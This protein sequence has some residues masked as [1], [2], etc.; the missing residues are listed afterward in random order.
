MKRSFLRSLFVRVGNWFGL[1]PEVGDLISAG[2]RLTNPGQADV[3]SE[4]LNFAS[5]LIASGIW[6]YCFFQFYRNFVGPYWVERQY[7]P[8][9]VSF[10]PRAVSPLSINVTHRT[11]MGFRGPNSPHF[12]MMDPAGAVCP[13]TGYYSIEFAVREQGRLFLSTRGELTIRQKPYLDLPIA[14]CEWRT[15]NTR[16]RMRATGS[17]EN[18][19]VLSLSCRTRLPDTELAISIRPFNPEGAALIHELS[20]APGAGG[21]VIR[22]NGEDEVFLPVAPDSVVVSNLQRGDAYFAENARRETHCPD[23]IATAVLSYRIDG[24]RELMFGARTYER[25]E[26]GDAAGSRAR[27]FPDGLSAQSLRESLSQSVAEWRKRLANGAAFQSARGGLNRAVRIMGGYLVSLRT[28]NEITP[29]SFT[30]RTFFFRDAAYMIPAL[31]QWNFAGEVKPILYSYAKRQL[32]T[33]FFRSQKGEWDS[34]GQAIWTLVEYCRATGD[35]T[36]LESAYPTLQKGVGWIWRLRRKGPGRK[37]LPPGFSAEHLG[38]ADCY[39]WDNVWSLAGIRATQR[40][41]LALGR[42]ADAASLKERYDRYA[43]DLLEVS[44]ADRVRLGVIPPAPGRAIEAGMIGSIAELYPLELGV[45]PR[46]QMKR[47]V[48]TVYKRFFSRGLFFHPI[49]HSGFNVYLSLQ[50]AQCFFRFG[51]IRRARRTLNRVLQKRTQMWTYPEAIHPLTGGG[52]MGDGF[53]GW[54]FAEVLL[55]VRQFTVHRS[56]E[57]LEVFRGLRRRELFGTPLKFGPFPMDGTTVSIQG[58]MNSLGG[59]LTIRIPGIV[60]TALT[61][62]RIHLPVSGLRVLSLEGAVAGPIGKNKLILMEPQEAVTVVFE[63]A[64]AGG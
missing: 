22:I 59:R 20:I 58:E 15:K 29:G 1:H 5:R 7:N 53:H 18:L 48:S 17:G 47:T 43:R 40:A 32:R 52:V 55:L 44:S 4:N 34:T 41:A 49:I 37:I 19:I 39:Y 35:R 10:I 54:A 62:F 21:Q 64:G 12:A 3:P 51:Q 11:W 38:P 56:D 60:R 24:R 36:L 16:I 42:S 2:F 46:A 13:V 61:S 14:A 6:N 45:F 31:V 50:M 27:K 9:D 33:G 30:Y 63:G 57:R 8:T 26:E 28:G 23:G 25:N